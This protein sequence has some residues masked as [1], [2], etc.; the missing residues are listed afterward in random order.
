MRECWPKSIIAVT[1][2]Q[3]CL[4]WHLRCD[5]IWCA[6]VVSTSLMSMCRVVLLQPGPSVTFQTNF[7]YSSVFL[8]RWRLWGCGSTA[9]HCTELHL[10]LFKSFRISAG[11]SLLEVVRK[12]GTSVNLTK[13]IWSNNNPKSKEKSKTFIVLIIRPCFYELRTL[14]CIV[15]FM[16]NKHILMIFLSALIN[17]ILWPDGVLRFSVQFFFCF[18]VLSPLFA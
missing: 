17:N 5:Y 1:D 9:A 14:F 18:F 8:E 15:I 3:L 13:K 4:R 10:S 6:G 7:S 2:A 12:C 11:E 16:T